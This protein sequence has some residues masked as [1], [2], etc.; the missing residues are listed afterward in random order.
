MKELK[1]RPIGVIHSP[2]TSP[3]GTPIQSAAGRALA[4]AGWRT[5]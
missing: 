1:I 3:K 5:W 4:R 2:F